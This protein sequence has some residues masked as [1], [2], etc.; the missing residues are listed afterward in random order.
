MKNKKTTR[1]QFIKTAGKTLATT[2]LL[3]GPISI[4]LD[5]ITR[6]AISR[7]VAE[8]A[9]VNPR[10]WVDMRLNGAPPRWV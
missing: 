8:A 2:A 3:D 10:K 7:A 5:A 4:V 1:R 9:G 6:G